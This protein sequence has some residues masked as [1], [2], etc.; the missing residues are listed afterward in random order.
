[1]E[2]WSLTASPI[3]NVKASGIEPTFNDSDATL[4]PTWLPWPGESAQITVSRP[5]AVP[6]NTLTVQSVSYTGNSGLREMDSNL[7]I[8]LQCT[9]GQNFY[10]QLPQ[11]CKVT[12]LQLDGMPYPVQFDSKQND[13]LV[14]ALLPTSTQLGIAWKINAPLG[15]VSKLP[16]IHF[17][18]SDDQGI[19]P[20][21]CY[22]T[23]Q[24]LTLPVGYLV[25]S[26]WGPLEGPA[27]RLWT[28]LLVLLG[29]SYLICRVPLFPIGTIPTF[30]LAF[31]LSQMAISMSII[32]LAWFFLVAWRGDA[33]FPERVKDH[34]LY[35][36]IQV[37]LMLMTLLFL[38]SVFRQ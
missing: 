4:T 16:S 17:F 23:R 12:S 36:A 30:L 32:P 37:L 33:K 27:V 34:G 25:L 3:W 20:V 18:H 5:V 14:V 1:V 19:E 15:F 2:K 8:A 31:G 13:R 21:V 35:N 38:Q 11:D 28:W 10:V 29:I 22:N 26:T 24:S 7:Q 9:V 6:G